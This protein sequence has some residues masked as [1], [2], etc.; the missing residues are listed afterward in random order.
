MSLVIGKGYIGKC[1]GYL[2]GQWSLQ[3]RDSVTRYVPVILLRFQ[4]K[5][6]VWRYAQYNCL[7][8]GKNIVSFTLKFLFMVV[9]PWDMWCGGL[10]TLHELVLIDSIVLIV[11]KN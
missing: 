7:F 11:D 1:H 8:S 10:I 4:E 6:F 2:T 9:M 3:I 5:Q